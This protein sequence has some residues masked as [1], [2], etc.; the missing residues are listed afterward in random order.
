MHPQVY[1]RAELL[2]LPEMKGSKLSLLSVVFQP[3]VF[4][5]SEPSLICFTPENMEQFFISTAVSRRNESVRRSG[6]K[7]LFIMM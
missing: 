2:F 1:F 4:I 3:S 6:D 7:T 5:H